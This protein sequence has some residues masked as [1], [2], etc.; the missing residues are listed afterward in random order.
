MG[1]KAKSSNSSKSDETRILIKREKKI[2]KNLGI[3]PNAPLGNIDSEVRELYRRCKV[4]HQ[5]YRAW[6]YL[7]SYEEIKTLIDII[8]YESETELSDNIN[9]VHFTKI[10]KQYAYLNSELHQHLNQFLK[11]G[12]K[13]LIN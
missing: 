3:D 11:E 10:K 9:K 13:H 7:Y 4:R 6:S 1:K 8:E 12:E 5:I 2:F